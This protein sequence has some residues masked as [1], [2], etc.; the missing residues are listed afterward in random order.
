MKTEN[1]KKLRFDKATLVE[2]TIPQLETIMGGGTTF[3]CGEC[4][5]IPTLIKSLK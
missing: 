5:L 1:P 3:T 2:L 4:V